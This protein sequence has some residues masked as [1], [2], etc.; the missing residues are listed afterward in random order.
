MTIPT[1]QELIKAGAHIGH[2]KSKWNPKMAPFVFG[3]RNNIHIIDV[4]A[5]VERL[6][7]ALKF[8]EG[9]IASGGKILFLGVNIQSRNAVK[10]TARALD[11]PYVV[12]RW[13]GGLITNFKVLKARIA[14]YRKLEVE[15]DSGGLA[16]YTKKEQV[17]LK[18]KLAKLEKELGGLKTLEKH[19]QAIFITDVERELAAVL[20]A[21]A[22]K[23][24]VVAIVDTD[25]DPTL[26]DW[27]IPANDSSTD[28]LKLIYRVV[29]EG[30]TPAVAAS[31]VAEAAKAAAAPSSNG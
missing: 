15:R 21:R 13:I 3:V 28:S 8:I 6:E 30:L 26:V 19:P 23:I 4:F 1:P 7:K 5:T 12:G 25:S 31:K 20:E 17:R 10:E 11:M 14:D 16:K 22:M 18:N 27:P 24:P 29:R 9:I 2:H